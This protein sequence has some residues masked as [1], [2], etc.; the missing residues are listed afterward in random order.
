MTGQDLFDEARARARKADDE[1]RRA[2]AITA[3]GV[4]GDERG[5]K[6]VFDLIRRARVLPLDR[7]GSG[8]RI[9]SRQR[10][11]L[12]RG[13]RLIGCEGGVELLA[14]LQSAAQGEAGGDRSLAAG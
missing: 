7:G 11:E 2:A 3:A 4:A 6:G 10:C 8:D 1:D 12:E 13:S 9:A 14:G 5:C